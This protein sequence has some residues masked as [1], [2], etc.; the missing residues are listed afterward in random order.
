MNWR[1]ALTFLVVA[2]LAPIVLLV[3][4]ALIAPLSLISPDLRRFVLSQWSSLAINHGFRRKQPT[5]KAA[6][7][8]KILEF[9]TSTWALAII[10]MALTGT[11][12]L[13]YLGSCLVIGSLVALINQART[14]VSHVW[15]NEAGQALTL[16]DQYRDSVNL[17]EP[18]LVT[19]L[20]APVGLRYHAL[21]HLVPSVPYHALEQ[22]HK[23][24]TNELGADSTYLSGNYQSLRAVIAQIW[25]GNVVHGRTIL[26]RPGK[27][28]DL[29]AWHLSRPYRN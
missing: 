19:S 7:E 26:G 11:G 28:I 29:R 24:I 27:G 5:G 12:S 14:L 18:S 22:V 6:R 4:F 16:T 3:R 1:Q 9:A 20:L 15:G 2:S 21:H 8:W 13:Q 17:P 23:R 25:P 10:G